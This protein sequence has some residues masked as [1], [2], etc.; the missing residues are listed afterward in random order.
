M[1]G[2]IS[3]TCFG[4][5]KKVEISISWEVGVVPA[6][7]YLYCYS[8]F[9]LTLP[10]T[11]ASRQF[12]EFFQVLGRIE[13]PNRPPASNPG[14]EVMGDVGESRVRSSLVFGWILPLLTLPEDV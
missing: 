5:H 4:G 10:C 6:A 7:L 1:E 8:F 13:L 14:T 9:M 11:G 12:L 3:T 2:Y